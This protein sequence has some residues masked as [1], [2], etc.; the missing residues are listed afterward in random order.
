MGEKAQVRHKSVEMSE[1]N[2][3]HFCLVPN[4]MTHC[5]ATVSCTQC[6]DHLISFFFFNECVSLLYAHLNGFFS[7][8]LV[9][10]LD[11]RST[12]HLSIGFSFLSDL[13]SRCISIITRTIWNMSKILLPHYLLNDNIDARYPKFHCCRVVLLLGAR[14]LFWGVLYCN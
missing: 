13:S 6:T 1:W 12:N 2:Q 10:F 5:S 4:L 8:S 11:E 14:C 7:F 3:S 9:F